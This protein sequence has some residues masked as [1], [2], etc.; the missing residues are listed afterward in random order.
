MPFNGSGTFLR[1]RN[2]VNDAAANI[3]IRADR[4]DSE[5]DNFALGLSQCI[6]KDGQTTITAD[7]PMASYRH[8]NVGEGT[9]LTHY[10]RYDQVLNGKTNWSVAT[11]TADALVVNHTVPFTAYVDG[12]LVNFR[13]A[14][15]NTTTTPTLAVDALTAKTMKKSGGDA[16]LVGDLTAGM[17]VT[18]RYNQSGDHFEIVFQ[19]T[20]SAGDVG[21]GTLPLAKLVDIP[22]RTFII[23]P[24]GASATPQ[25]GSVEDYLATT[26]IIGL[27]LSNNA[28]DAANDMD[29]AVGACWSSDQT[30]RMN[31][32]TALTKQTDAP[33]AEGNN[34]GAMLNGDTMPA[35]TG[36]L[37]WWVI[38]KADGTT[39]IGAT[40][41]ATTGT[42]LVVGDLPAGFT[43]LRYIGSWAVEGGAL[44]EMTQEGDSTYFNTSTVDYSA[45]PATGAD[46]PLRLPSVPVIANLMANASSAGSSR[47]VALRSKVYGSPGWAISGANLNC[48]T[49]SDANADTIT[50]GGQYFLRSDDGAITCTNVATTTLSVI[51]VGWTDLRRQEFS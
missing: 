43:K 6:T 42:G 48:G 14:A 19:Y 21:D 41:Q 28:T 3:R 16:L 49:Y 17:E 39:D 44:E 4:H 8:T 11:G 33:F 2:W 24:T 50:S 5:D 7:L 20:F 26:T 10:A 12:M 23:N 34:A 29:I 35:G 18:A 47:G 38:T 9:A 22:A 45:N 30:T 25:A 1:V 27:T 13:V 31:L 36:F 37:N 51:T 46:I 40:N 32:T 15:A